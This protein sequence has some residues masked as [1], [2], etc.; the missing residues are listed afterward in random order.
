MPLHYRPYPDKLVFHAIFL[1]TF[2]VQ[3]GLNFKENFQNRPKRRK[4]NNLIIMIAKWL[5]KKRYVLIVYDVLDDKSR[6][7]IALLS[8]VPK[9]NWPTTIKNT[10]ANCQKSYTKWVNSCLSW[11]S[12]SMYC[13]DSMNVTCQIRIMLYQMLNPW[14]MLKPLTDGIY[15]QRGAV[16]GLKVQSL[17]TV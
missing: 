8:A 2:L 12:R 11:D 16:K 4:H 13:T 15:N 14:L 9:S 1:L 7:Q 5:M 6:K 3:K 17:L 10:S